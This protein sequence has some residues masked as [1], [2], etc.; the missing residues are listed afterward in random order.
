M[1]FSLSLRD[2]SWE[3]AAAAPPPRPPL[4]LA[5]ET[6]PLSSVPLNPLG[7]PHNPLKILGELTLKRLSVIGQGSPDDL[8]SVVGV[9]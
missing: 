9:G 8:K 1:F 2:L 7:K 3:L 6:Q 5:H 4:F